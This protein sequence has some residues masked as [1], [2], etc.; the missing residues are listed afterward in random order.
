MPCPCQDCIDI[1]SS[2]TSTSSSLQH[3]SDKT[4]FELLSNGD[5]METMD[6]HSVE[7][8]TSTFTSASPVTSGTNAIKALF[9][10]HN[11]AVNYS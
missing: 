10:E 5:A 4:T 11:S 7:L 2:S 3:K 9:A 8:L 6:N 1:T